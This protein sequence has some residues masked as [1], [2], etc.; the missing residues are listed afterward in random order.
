[1]FSCGIP[2]STSGGMKDGLTT[3]I[4][5]ALRYVPITYFL[6]ILK[7]N[8]GILIEPSKVDGI[9]CT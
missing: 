1:M 9:K 4:S 5:S 8:F 2:N 6:K 7:S 3:T